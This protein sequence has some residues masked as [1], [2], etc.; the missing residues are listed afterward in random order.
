MQF[1]CKCLVT[2]ICLALFWALGTWEGI[3]TAPALNL[4]GEAA[5]YI[6]NYST[7]QGVMIEALLGVLRTEKR[8]KCGEE[9]KG[10]W[11]EP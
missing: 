8:E 7:M 10:N 9:G 3:S 2:A 11:H 5:M 1:N 4:A 6:D